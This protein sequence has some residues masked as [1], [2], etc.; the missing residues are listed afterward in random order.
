[1]F[2][3]EIKNSLRYKKIKKFHQVAALRS[4]F[5]F[6][7]GSENF[8]PLLAVA[9]DSLSNASA[10][11]YARAD[12][13]CCGIM[14]FSFFQSILFTFYFSFDFFFFLILQQQKLD[15]LRTG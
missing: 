3:F 10:L 1:L 15:N 11:A 8:E 13:I 6:G 2:L 9:V 7:R 12:S 14:S 5:T 4:E